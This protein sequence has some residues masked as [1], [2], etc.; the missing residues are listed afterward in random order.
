MSTPFALNE[1]VSWR[2]RGVVGL[3]VTMSGDGRTLTLKAFAGQVVPGVPAG[4]CHYATKAEIAE[5]R[6]RPLAGPNPGVT[7]TKQ[8]GIEAEA[9]AELRKSIDLAR[10]IVAGLDT[11]IPLSRQISSL[12]A[13]VLSLEMLLAG[14]LHNVTEAVRMGEALV[15]QDAPA[16]KRIVAKHGGRA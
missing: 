9:I 16:L 4:E 14:V 2:G 8:A 10:R 15:V 11:R 1:V 12:A 7:A 6:V 3:V 5:A 13:G